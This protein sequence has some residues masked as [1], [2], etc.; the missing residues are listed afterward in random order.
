M[1]RIQI[2]AILVVFIAC[3]RT[4]KT[5]SFIGLPIVDSNNNMSGETLKFMDSKEADTYYDFAVNFAADSTNIK[6][7]TA[8]SLLGDT[9]F[10]GI[11]IPFRS[12][13]F[14]NGISL[15][16]KAVYLSKE[17]KLLDYTAYLSGNI[18]PNSGMKLVSIRLVKNSNFSTAGHL[19]VSWT[20]P[21][22][23][24]SEIG[25]IVNSDFKISNPRF[26][27]EQYA[28][29]APSFLLK[30]AANNVTSV[31][32]FEVIYNKKKEIIS[33]RISK[34]GKDQ[35]DTKIGNLSRVRNYQA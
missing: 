15:H 27:Q 21:K 33:I 19:L 12:N 16:F 22:A 20:F 25:R 5:K 24:K 9:T 35:I 32:G 17:D 14:S 23:V 28:Y 3:N 26:I 10:V 18:F 7:S 8:H 4:P 29:S 13:A 34:N 2:V 30:M 6:C 1:K 11:Q 31:I